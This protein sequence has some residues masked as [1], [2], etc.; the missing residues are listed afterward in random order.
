M[1]KHVL[2]LTLGL[3]AVAIVFSGCNKPTERPSKMDP[4][5]EG[6]VMEM[7]KLGAGEI[8]GSSKAVL[9]TGSEKDLSAMNSESVT[10]SQVKLE[11]DLEKITQKVTTPAKAAAI[12]EHLSQPN[13]VI[14]IVV[15]ETEVKILKVTPEVTNSNPA[16]I[17]S[18]LQLFDA[19]KAMS[20]T[21]NAQTQAELAQKMD[22]VKF[23]SPAQLG[24]KFGLVELASVKVEKYGVLEDKRTEYGERMSITTL[25][26]VPFEMSTHLILGDEVGAES[27]AASQD[28]TTAAQ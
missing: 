25:N 26:Q 7:S 5:I 15:L 18:S 9:F 16:Y 14:A 6:K 28:S 3:T 21:S 27:E 10:L 8:T 24:E 22:E 1:K 19:M 23:K 13:G 4:E 20:R 11:G 2:S 12:A 17:V